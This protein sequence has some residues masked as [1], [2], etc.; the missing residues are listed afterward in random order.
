M[1]QQQKLGKLCDGLVDMWY[2][3]DLLLFVLFELMAARIWAG[4]TGVLREL[5]SCNSPT[6]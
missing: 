3:R 2:E 1:Q 4:Q 6:S 5:F